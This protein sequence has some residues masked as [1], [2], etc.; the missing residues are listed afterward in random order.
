MPQI[1]LLALMGLPAAGKTELSN[2]LLQQ[3]QQLNWNIL[4]LCYDNYLN[5][6]VEQKQQRDDLLQQLSQRIDVLQAEN[7]TTNHLIICD[8]NHYYRSMRY[9][10]YQLCRSKHCLYAQLYL[11]TSLEDCLQRN[12]AR[13]SPVPTTIIEQ[14]QQ[15]LEAPGPA[16]WERHQLTLDGFNQQAICDFLKTLL[17]AEVV[18][19]LP[20]SSV[21]QLQPQAPTHQLDLLLRQRIAL[22]MREDTP[23]KAARSRDLNAQRK[24]LLAQF[25]RETNCN[26]EQLQHYVNLLQL[27]DKHQT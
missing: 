3:Q 13:P 5:N 6:F 20:Q 24:Q 25:K 12:A 23:S 9:K 21:K 16:A 19:E 11:A 18:E 2:W 22:L 8:D 7:R 15:R 10:L 27:V 1:C 17:Q 14:M 26:G 4:H